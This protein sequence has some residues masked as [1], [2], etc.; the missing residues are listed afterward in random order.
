MQ[1]FRAMLDEVTPVAVKYLELSGDFNSVRQQQ[2]DCRR[3]LMAEADILR[4]C[5]GHRNICLF[6]GAYFGEVSRSSPRH[7]A[8][9]ELLSSVCACHMRPAAQYLW[10]QAGAICTHLML[11]LS[12]LAVLAECLFASS[13]TA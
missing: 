9:R 4:E 10:L 6:I 5:R 13:D 1:V 2:R 12:V 8:G 7:K 3:R 11:T